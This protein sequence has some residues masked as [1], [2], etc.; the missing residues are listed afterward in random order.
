MLCIMKNFNFEIVLYFRKVT[1]IV[2]SASIYPS[3][4]P[5]VH[6]QHNHS[7]VIKVRKRIA[8]SPYYS[9]VYSPHLNFASFP[10][11]PFVQPRSQA[12]G[13]HRMLFIFLLSL[14]QCTQFHQPFTFPTLVFLKSSSYFTECSSIWICLMF[15][16]DQ[17][18]VMHLGQEYHGSNVVYFSMHFSEGT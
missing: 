17:T 12:R 16:H 2:Q 1:K 11:M 13:S 8:L 14:L 10:L 5:N 6:I 4:I 9:L 18:K 7:V 3:S 15:P